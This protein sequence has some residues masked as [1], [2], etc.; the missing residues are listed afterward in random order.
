MERRKNNLLIGL[1]FYLENSLLF[2]FFLLYIYFVTSPGY[3]NKFHALSN[4]VPNGKKKK[5]KQ[6]ETFFFLLPPFRQYQ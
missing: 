1:T 4:H 3:E 6:K 5:H 2:C